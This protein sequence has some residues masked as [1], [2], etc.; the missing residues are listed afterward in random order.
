MRSVN[1]ERMR[2]AFQD[3]GVGSRRTSPARVTEYSRLAPESPGRGDGQP[4]VARL[5]G[6]PG[7]DAAGKGNPPLARPTAA[8]RAR[9]TESS[10]RTIHIH[11]LFDTTA[12][13]RR[14]RRR[15]WA[16]TGRRQA[17]ICP[18]W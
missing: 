5:S 7:L 18:G 4:E 13:T 6:R 15:R 9:D 17:R 1:S 14:R 2:A 10:Y 8:R 12:L 11:P 3:S 16:R